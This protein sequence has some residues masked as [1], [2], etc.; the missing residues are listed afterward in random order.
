MMHFNLTKE[1]AKPLSKHLKPAR[2]LQ[3]DLIWRGDIALIGSD[4]CVVM[5]EQHSQYIMVM[6]GLRN[7]DFTHFPILFR[8]RFWRE[9]AAICKQG[10]VYDTQVLAKYLNQLCEKQYYQLDPEPLEEGKLT[11]VMEKLERRFLYDRLPLPVDGRAAFEFSFQINSKQAK[12][13]QGKGKLS[14]AEMLGNICL[15]LI[16][17]RM[18]EEKKAA[19]PVLFEE[20]NIVRVDFARRRS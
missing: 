9:A 19:D 10:N 5:Q 17:I 11:K 7:E 20:D 12:I 6:C 2:L 14:P 3:P 15:N 18:E 13:E 4:L 8:D 1:L 16:E